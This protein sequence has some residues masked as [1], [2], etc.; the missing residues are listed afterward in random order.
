MC[1][2][3]IGFFNCFISLEWFIFCFT[4]VRT[5]RSL[6]VGTRPVQSYFFELFIALRLTEQACLPYVCSVVRGPVLSCGEFL[7]GRKQATVMCLG[8]IIPSVEWKLWVN[9]SGCTWQKQSIWLKRH[10]TFLEQRCACRNG[11]ISWCIG[12][13]LY[14]TLADVGGGIAG[15][16]ARILFPCWKNKTVPTSHHTQKIDFRCSKETGRKQNL[17]TFKKK[18][19]RVS[20]IPDIWQGRMLQEDTDRAVKI[21]I[22]KC[23]CQMS[24]PQKMPES[25][26]HEGEATGPVHG[27][28]NAQFIIMLHKVHT[29]PLKKFIKFE[30]KDY[31]SAKSVWN[32]DIF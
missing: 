22:G 17:K 20:L 8:P 29:R 3:L 5:V 12:L 7:W 4:Y 31:L 32:L 19:R 2:K 25:R 21:R 26:N 23:D 6:R 1:L 9:S 16:W 28:E 24:L 27:F 11:H 15:H 13:C 18:P 30:L 10:R 14:T